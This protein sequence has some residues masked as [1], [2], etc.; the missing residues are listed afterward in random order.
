MHEDATQRLKSGALTPPRVE[1]YREAA[2]K[3][4][5]Y[6]GVTGV[7]K[8]RMNKY[9]YKGNFSSFV[10]Y[11]LSMEKTNVNSMWCHLW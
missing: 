4:F 1:G 5:V 11:F 10:F 6:Y 3:Y 7:P 2:S 9:G 8:L